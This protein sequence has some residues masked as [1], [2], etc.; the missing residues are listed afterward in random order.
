MANI[1]SQLPPNKTDKILVTYASRSGSTAEIATAISKTLADCGLDVVLLPMQAVDDITPYRAVVAGSAIQRQKWLPEAMEFME[2]HQKEL[3]HKPF[4][5]FLVCIALS[6]QNERWTRAASTWLE[7]V[8]A[9]V[10]P[11]SEGL[12]AGV[13]DI[14]KV[15]L[16]YRLLFRLSVLFG[17]FSEGDYRDWE[18]IRTWAEQLPAELLA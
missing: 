1:P 16:Q 17:P 7:P 4:A 9:L 5:A 3:A 2:R 6:L 15:P 12:F 13:M 10:K 8:R 14:K 11:T 18:G